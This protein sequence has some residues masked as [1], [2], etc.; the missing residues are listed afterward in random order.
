MLTYCHI[1]SG[2]RHSQADV[3]SQG[4]VEAEHACVVEELAEDHLT[5][6]RG[7]GCA[8]DG[9]NRC[10]TVSIRD[11]RAHFTGQATE[12]KHTVRGKKTLV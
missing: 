7:R 1:D 3:I 11:D 12:K 6:W 10:D 4:D 2:A 8:A 9:L 5:V